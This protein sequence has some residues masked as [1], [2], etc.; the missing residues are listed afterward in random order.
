MPCPRRSKNGRPANHSL[1]QCVDLNRWKNNEVQ[2]ALQGAN[3]SGGPGPGGNPATGPLTGANAVPTGNTG[4]G[5]NTGNQ[6][7]F[8]QQ[9]RQL[10][11]YHIYTSG[12]TKRERKIVKRAVN[13]VVTGVPRYLRWSEHTVTWSRADHPEAVEH[14]GLLALVVAPQVH[15]FELKKVL[16][17]GGSSINI[18]YW[19]TFIRMGLKES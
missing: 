12:T 4:A 19:D 8:S 15:G 6:G 17:D 18:L 11:Q 14:P 1:A 5:Q 3:R 9:P 16:M 7:G 2:R 13:A 10:G